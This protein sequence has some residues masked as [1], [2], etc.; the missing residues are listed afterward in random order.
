MEYLW[1]VLPKMVLVLLNLLWLVQLPKILAVGLLQPN[2]CG[3]FSASVSSNYGHELF[4]INGDLVD[5]EWFCNALKLYISDRCLIV[6]NLGTHYC[7]LSIALG[8]DPS[9]LCAGYLFHV[10]K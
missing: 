6:K 8:T 3:M 2:E 10:L 9:V 5:Q 4:Y 1:N 7:G